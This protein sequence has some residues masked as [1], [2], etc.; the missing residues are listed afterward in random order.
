MRLK[1][2]LRLKNS[3]VIGPFTQD[4]IGELYFKKHINGDEDC[5]L[6]PIGDWQ[7]FSL[8][9]SLV[10]LVETIKNN[11]RTITKLE[12]SKTDNVQSSENEQALAELKQ[13]KE[14]REFQFDKDLKSKIDYG[15]LER[16]YNLENHNP[17][18]AKDEEFDKTR[19][20]KSRIK[21]KKE[22][23][24]DKTVFIPSKAKFS[25]EI[26]I[27][28]EK[29]KSK[30]QKEIVTKIYE[31]LPAF[32]SDDLVNENTEFFNIDL[33]L[34]SIRAQLV[35]SE[36]EFNIKERIEESN[37]QIRQN[38][39]IEEMQR[40]S[41]RESERES[42]NDNDDDDYNPND[43]QPEILLNNNGTSKIE[44][45]VRRKRKKSMSVIAAV[46]FI[47]IA[48]FFL[49]PEDK[50]EIKEPHFLEIKFP[51]VEQAEDL[52]ASKVA[53]NKGRE[54]YAK[55]TYL[56]RV[57]ASQSYVTSLEKKF[58]NNDALGELILSY[59]GLLDNSKYPKIAA[60]TIYKLIQLSEN[61]M[62]SDLNTVIGTSLFF[63]KIE[64]YQTGISLIKNYL[65]TKKQISNM[66]LTSYLDLLI[67][68]G[69]LVE[70][71]KIFT[72]LKELPQKSFETYSSLAHFYEV[73]DKQ[74]EALKII[75]EGLKYFPN[76]VLLLL[77]KA[78]CLFKDHSLGKYEE[79]L[80][81][82]NTLNS[83][84]SPVFT[85]RFY[86]H[87]GILSAFKKKNKEATTFFKKSL[88]IK[89]SDELRNMLSNLFVVGDK[90]T[91]SL[92]AE[93]KVLDLIKK[94]NEELKNN[95]FQAAFSYSIEAVDTSPDYIP[96]ILLQTKLQ[97]RRGLFDSAIS[98]LQRAIAMNP[99]NYLLIKNLITAYMNAYKF[100]DAQRMLV[101]LSQTKYSTTSEFATLTGDFYIL[102]NN[103]KLASRWF[104]E[105]LNRDPLNDYNMYQIAKIY[106]R[107]KKFKQAKNI[108][109][110][111]ILLNPKNPEYLSM[112]AEILF[113]EDNTDTAIG[114]LRDVILEVGEDP[115]LLSSIAS[116]YYKS[117]QIK[118]FNNYYKR[119]QAL[120]KKDETFYEFLIYTAKIEENTSDVVNYSRE[121]LKLNPGNLKVR[122]ELGE[123]LFNQKKYA[124]AVVEF[125]EVRLKLL[126]YPRVHYML[127]KTYL[128]MLDIGNAK[129]NALKELE[130]NPTLDVAYFIVGEVARLEHDYREATLK[131]EKA[132][133]LN[134]K[135]VDA[136]MALA[137]I[138]LAQNYASEAI[139]I[140]G[141]AL[142]EDRN[143][144][145]I[146][147]Q[148]G[149]AYK[150][151]GQRALAKEKF[152]DY[153]KLNPAAA[154]KTQIDLQIKN[155]Q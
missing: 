40:E 149:L 49:M 84:G 12:I 140:Y 51:I 44:K 68:A 104:N 114:Y 41:E 134:P 63:E 5:Q 130:L 72:K 52:I 99:K 128:G 111:A 54:F 14:Y 121:L 56:S 132:I 139:E 83:E 59:S 2:R 36:A 129:K 37:E 150:A 137:W 118:E 24:L 45:P 95:N 155:L 88:A 21:V 61:K 42:D 66:L 96:A 28:Q 30:E 60:N 113:E 27:Q 39:L 53:L 13:I 75:D 1:Y 29:I 10:S 102:E 81:K 123:F 135:S 23:D 107:L 124:E 32:T 138:R 9:P 64:K 38:A 100:E 62:L 3:R 106:L 16:K 6:F 80:K 18:E 90:F 15:E 141:R 7:S 89:E 126:S 120:P 101:E 146:Y 78:D 117:G 108:L 91:Q 19:I 71:R 47:G 87:M 144:S 17:V 98:T 33:A 151:M 43:L 11:D 8:F 55:G 154:D 116:F 77:K 58:T 73:D 92:I 109:A 70:A 67:N 74:S 35:I 46:T 143:N 31:N 136:L 152:E 110:K 142:R 105:A 48:Y 148:M 69:E 50:I 153:L 122:L 147:K 112:N 97:I 34:P 125:E 115:K 22:L 133:S 25:S 94:S 4:E 145:E 86:Y 131:Y 85:A 26:L 57:L 20:I 103:V 65:R 82:I 127:A 119:I 76:S 79:V 93:S